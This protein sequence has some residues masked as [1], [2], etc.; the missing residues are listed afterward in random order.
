[1]T[2]LGEAIARYHKL[3]ESESFKDMAW[4]EAVREQ[5][6]ARG[7]TS[8]GRPISPV[9]RPHFVTRRQYANLVKAAESLFSAIDRIK[10]L[11][12]ATPQLL[13]RMELLPAEKML[14]SVDPGYPFLAV[15][16]L[17]DTHLDNGALHFV[18]YNAD[19]PAGVAYSD[20]LAD[21][22]FDCPPMRQFRKRYAVAKPGG[23]KHLL[24]A[25]LRAYKE[26]TNGKKKAPHIAVVEIRQP[27]QTSESGE[28]LLM[29]EYFRREGYPAEIIAPEHLEYRGG[30]LRRG[31][32]TIDLVYRRV[33]VQ[34]FLVRYD[35]NHPLVRAY[36]DRAACVVN[37][38]RSELAHKKAI[39]DLLTDDSITSGFP[40]AERK[41]IR[42]YIPWTRVV[43]AAK[44]AYRD[45]IVD[46]PEFILKNRER[47]VLKPND[48]SADQHSF[49]GW[50]TDPA[51]WER[52]LRTAMR[53]PYVVQERI[54]A[55]VIPFPVYRDGALEMRDMQ[56]DVHPHA[57]LG[58]VQGCSSWLTVAGSGGFST[59][60]GLAATFVIEN[61]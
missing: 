37:S 3:I 21:I 8:G 53:H 46:L 60:S 39:F 49:L 34:E 29:R 43:A 61:K 30:V 22:F 57:F 31:D 59:L 7:L 52:A 42:E 2:Q 4:A 11:A 1:M 36:R 19:T 27:Y 33:K 14:A 51:G 10:Q 20:G 55:P 28:L 24:D 16:S 41:A 58:R 25:L 9:L 13:N 40:M 32:F 56:V 38:F 50:E 6:R 35:L 45:E 26:F 23:M 44:A 18:E 48:E 47:L 54:P 5:M 15:T 17:L 12:L